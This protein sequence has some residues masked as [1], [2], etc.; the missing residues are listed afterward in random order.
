MV[1]ALNLALRQAMANDDRVLV[2]GEDVAQTGGVFRVTAGLLEQFGEER[3]VD[4]PLAEAGIV[5]AAIGMAVYGLLP[6]VEIQFDVFVYPGFEQ[7]VVHAA[8]YAW[9]TKGEVPASIV[10]R[11]PFGGGV[12]APELHSDSPEALFAHVPGLKVVCPTTPRD[13][14][15]MMLAAIEDPDPVVF[16]EPKRIYRAGRQ[17]VPE[18]LPFEFSNGHEKRNQLLSTARVAREGTD[19]A[20]ITYGPALPLCM[21]A[22]DRMANEHHVDC[23]VLD[24]RSLYP[25]DVDAIIS[26][27]SRCHRAL[28][29][30]E[31]PRMAGIGA[32]VSSLIHERTMLELEA[33]ALRVTGFDVPFPQFANED[34]Y[35]P[36]VDRIL[37]GALKVLHY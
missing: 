6:V 25:L 2:L 33:P 16:M 4:T 14:R 27:A 31:A 34:D 9:R 5:G 12:R 15:D 30:H 19:L 29:V 28:I 22:A 35:L 26:S 23:Q 36:S 8:R 13:A 20:M 37:A 17:D 11:I 7:I 24:L 10:V 1:E 18:Q 3:V 21:Q 32:E